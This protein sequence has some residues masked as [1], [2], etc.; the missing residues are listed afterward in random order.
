MT[1]NDSKNSSRRHFN[2]LIGA[3]ALLSL[4]GCL[5]DLTGGS[6]PERQDPSARIQDV[7]IK[8]VPEGYSQNRFFVAISDDLL[9]SDYTIFNGQQLRVRPNSSSGSRGDAV[10]YTVTTD[11]TYSDQEENTIWVSNSGMERLDSTDGTVD[12]IPY[13]TSPVY[14]SRNEGR[15]NAE[16]IEQTNDGNPSILFISPHGGQLYTNTELQAFRGASQNDY[17][18]WSVAGYGET[19]S[20]AW[21][22]WYNPEDRYS[23]ESFYGLQ[24][25]RESYET[26]VSFS[27]NSLP[28]RKIIIGGLTSTELKEAVKEE[29]EYVFYGSQRSYVEGAENEDRSALDDSVDIEIQTSGEEAGVDPRLISNRLSTSGGGTLRI[30]Q[31]DSVREEYWQEIADS[32]IRAVETLRE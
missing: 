1:E 20:Q 6:D 27:G 18:V 21:R 17:S 23:V 25:L 12:V 30:S 16:F 15:E 31:T 2:K 24:E 22:R 5:E 10:L 28:I 7:E 9:D 14:F 13:S 32:V 4:S 3:G 26:V 29:L 19:E 11:P 8:Q